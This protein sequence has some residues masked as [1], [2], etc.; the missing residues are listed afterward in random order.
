MTWIFFCAMRCYFW[1]LFSYALG[2]EC[3]TRPLITV[4]KRWK[5]PKAYVAF[6][7]EQRTGQHRSLTMFYLSSKS[8][9]SQICRIFHHSGTG[10]H[11]S[12]TVDSGHPKSQVQCYIDAMLANNITQPRTIFLGTAIIWSVVMGSTKRW[13]LIYITHNCQL[14]ITR[15]GDKTLRTCCIVSPFLARHF[16]ANFLAISLKNTSFPQPVSHSAFSI[17]QQC[18]NLMWF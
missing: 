12:G 2:L 11:S 10:F 17:G 14:G 15:R 18:K 4:Q 3:D 5:L 6:V 1:L 13:D 7:A 8:A 9:K 16:P